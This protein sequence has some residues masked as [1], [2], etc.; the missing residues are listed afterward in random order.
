MIT[1]KTL[2]D[3]ISKT[4]K[5]TRG[6]SPRLFKMMKEM[7][8]IIIISSILSKSSAATAVFNHNLASSWYGPEY[9]LC[10]VVFLS[11]KFQVAIT[12]ETGHSLYQPMYQ[13]FC[14]TPGDRKT[15]LQVSN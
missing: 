5:N 7:I 12:I 14:S 9:L 8:I 6:D 3:T 4:C 11:F 15:Q 1:N 13:I 2:C 10:G